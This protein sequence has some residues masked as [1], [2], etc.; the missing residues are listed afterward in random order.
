MTNPTSPEKHYRVLRA[1]AFGLLGWLLMGAGLWVF[2]EG[3]A[4]ANRPHEVSGQWAVA[5][6]ALVCAAL[7]I[8]I[9]VQLV[10]NFREDGL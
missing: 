10:R 7:A 9:P 2:M 5:G 1:G 8:V 4:T 6:L 3:V